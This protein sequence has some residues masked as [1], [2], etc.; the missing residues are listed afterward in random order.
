MTPPAPNDDKQTEYDAFLSYSHRDRH[1]ATAIHK[2]LHRI[3]RRLGRL[4]ALRVFRD[5]TNLAAS[6]DLWGK[7]T[8]ALDQARY[9]IVVLSPQSAASHWVNE[10]VRYWLAH[11][12]AEHLMLVLAEGQ[13]RWDAT[14]GRFDPEQS[15]AA[16]PALTEPG[17]LG[18][19]P[20]YIDVSGDDPWDLGSL[21]FRDK[22]TALAAP[23][24]GKPKDDLAGE[25]LREQRQFRRLRTAA[26]GGLVVLTVVA[27]VAALVAVAKQQEANRRL[28]EAVV[29]KLNAEGAAMLAGTTPGGDVRALQELLAANAIQANGVPILNAQISRFTTQKIIDTG[30]MGFDVAYS[31]DGRRIVS[32]QADK[33]V[34]QWDSATGR[35]IGTPMKGHTDRVQ[36]VAYIPDGHTIASAALDGTMRLY[37]ADTGAELNRDPQHVD[38]LHALAVSP[39]GRT[40]FTAGENGT[41]QLWD[42]GSGRLR[43]IQQVFSNPAASISD[44]SVDRSGNLLA[45]SSE[46][47]RV[48]IYDTNSLTPHGPTIQV[49]LANG[50]PAGA[51]RIAFSPDGHTVALATTD[52]QIWDVDTGTLVHRIR[53]GLSVGEEALSAAFS[54]D[55]HRIVT[56]RSDGALQ[57]WDA[58][59][60]AQLGQTMTGHTGMVQGVKFSADG[61]QIASIGFDR[62][63]RLWSATVGQPMRGPDEF[64][65]QVAFSPDG[66]RVG[67]SGDLAVQQW[68]VSTG[69]PLSPLMPAGAGPKSFGYVDGHR[70]VTAAWDGTTQVFSENTG[71]P[72]QPPVRLSIVGDGQFLFAY[73]HDGHTIVS[74]GVANRTVQLWDVAT[75]KQLRQPITV[76]SPRGSLSG[77]ALSPDGRRLAGGYD[78]GL[79][80]WDLDSTQREAP[81]LIDPADHVNPILSVA[82]SRDGET[83]GAGNFDRLELWDCTTRK[84]LPHSPIRGHRGIVTGI[85]FGVGQQLATGGIDATLRLWDA[86]TGEATA[87]PQS[88]SDAITGVAIS[89][90]G[91]LAASANAD[92]SVLLSPAVADAARLCDKLPANMNPKQWRDWIS[93]SIDYITLCPGLPTAPD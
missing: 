74:G 36:A 28:R 82:F 61:R 10:E 13:L 91:R 4:R 18:S 46:D 90:D 56:G 20:L 71:Q 78:D 69:Q 58:D 29:A 12:G 85:A 35:P 40:V 76:N 55:G 53:L 26:I 77:L 6:P 87:S 81:L 93:P 24:H 31:P 88:R 45:A 48:A 42:A 23:I 2:G 21:T 72:V 14:S 75:G 39:D 57:L 19:E 41:V 80:L 15:D 59:S 92:G 65:G 11:R 63:M 66:H 84:Q 83:L 79:R 44:L 37:N 62:T 16:P 67:A 73:S 33:S 25:D 5:D 51:Y 38:R 22:V 47:G 52:L 54:P 60:G 30:S 89:P 32:A 8:E 3:G 9:L 64:V 70:I 86:A 17:S 1:V 27:V 50:W 7:I 43:A 34:R 68:D 49:R